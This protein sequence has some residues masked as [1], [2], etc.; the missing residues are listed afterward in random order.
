MKKKNEVVPVSKDVCRSKASN[1]YHYSGFWDGMH[2]YQKE[3]KDEKGIVNGYLVL[4]FYPSD[5]TPGNIEFCMKH[6]ITRIPKGER[7]YVH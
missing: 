1:G 6:E 4:Q 3:N 7:G 2:H 5:F